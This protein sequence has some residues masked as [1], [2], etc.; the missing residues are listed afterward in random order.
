[1]DGATDVTRRYVRLPIQY[2]APRSRAPEEAILWTIH[3][4]RKVRR[5]KMSQTERERLVKEDIREEKELRGFMASA[6]AMGLR[7]LLSSPSTSR[8][9]DQKT[10]VSRQEGTAT[11][12]QTRQPGG[13]GNSGPDR[14]GEG[15]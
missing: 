1:M 14:G 15:R 5:E 4:I 11:W 8:L 9:E 6:L 10:P 12:L 3:E 2:A 7:S 13:T